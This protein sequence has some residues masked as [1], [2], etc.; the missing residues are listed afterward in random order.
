MCHGIVPCKQ[1]AIGRV[2][3]CGL[4]MSPNGTSQK[5]CTRLLMRRRENLHYICC[6]L[7]F[8][9]EEPFDPAGPSGQNTHRSVF[10]TRPVHRCAMDQARKWRAET[11]QPRAGWPMQRAG[12]P[13]SRP[14]PILQHP[15]RQSGCWRRQPGALRDDKGRVVDLYRHPHNRSDSK[16]G[17]V[18]GAAR[19]SSAWTGAGAVA[20]P[21]GRPPSS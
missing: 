13:V 10:G 14:L 18:V 12:T 8:E 15:R 20:R 2:G 11:L 3:C 4:G 6:S 16:S 21:A 17:P 7:L 5:R 1:P 9:P 19:T